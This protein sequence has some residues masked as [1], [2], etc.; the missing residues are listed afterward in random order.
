MRRFL[1]KKDL[2]L[3]K[4]QTIYTIIGVVVIIGI[5][6]FL[7]REKKTEPEAPIVSVAPAQQQD[8]EIYGEYV[9]RIRAQQFVEVR[10]R[11]EGFLEQMLFE[12]GT[13]VK[14]NQV[15]FI[16]NQDQYQ[17]KVDK[18]RAQL[19]KDEAT[20]RK[21]ERDLNR[22]RPLYEQRAASQLDLDNA[23]AAYETAVAS[24]GMSQADLD[25][26]EQELSYTVVR[27]PITGQI[28][29]RHVDLG[30]L[31]GTS[32]KSLLATI[33]KSDTVLVDFSMTA[34]DYLKSKERNIIIGQKDSTRSWQPTVTI[35]L[36]DNTVYPY[37]GL[38][39]FAEPQVDPKTG[40]FSVRAE[41]SNPEH[42]LLPG[43][44]TKVKLLL[45]VRENAT[46]VPQKA[47]IIEKGGAY[48]YV[49]RKDSTAEK[50]FIELG[51]EFGNNAVVER[52]L[53]PGENIVVEGYHK[54]SPGIKMRI[55]TAPIEKE[56]ENKD[57]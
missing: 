38:V 23:T 49:M 17:A 42:V 47:L 18:A 40:T 45:D 37:K 20:A 51:P 39:D 36:P 21:A 12:E 25:Q 1:T 5:Y 41:M 33:V 31:V 11:V 44:F 22:I 14:R 8:V 15:L 55:G 3:K 46:V 56:E 2:K 4:K 48:I 24:V 54:L 13:Q 19:K 52:G 27:S 57:E 9:G 28:S 6:L 43:Q 32:G 34:L 50:R 35:T 16:I 10:A 7:T 30:T 26:A 53:I 29:E